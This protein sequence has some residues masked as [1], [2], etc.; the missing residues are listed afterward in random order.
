MSLADLLGPEFEASPS[1]M[2][3]VDRFHPSPAGYAR[4]ASALLPSV[5]AEA[6]LPRLVAVV[7]LDL[8][9][10]LVKRGKVMATS[11]RSRPLEKLVASVG[12]RQGDKDPDPS[13]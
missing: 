4:V 11:L 7:E 2:F 3:S 5:A 9:A 8:G 13:S 6:D 1:V 12:P 10:L